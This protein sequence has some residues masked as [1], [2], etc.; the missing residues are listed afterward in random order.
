[1][2]LH[3]L[4]VGWSMSRCIAD[5]ART[6]VSSGSRSRDL[7]RS[8]RIS[9]ASLSSVANLAPDSTD[10]APSYNLLQ[11]AYSLQPAPDTKYSPIPSFSGPI[12]PVPALKRPQ[13]ATCSKLDSLYS[14][15]TSRRPVSESFPGKG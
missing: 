9:S 2:L 1:M 8:R 12:C 6:G 4:T 10:F 5:G 13:S 7:S 15:P 11:P 14:P 3:A